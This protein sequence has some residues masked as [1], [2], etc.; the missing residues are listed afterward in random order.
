MKKTFL[1]LGCLTLLTVGIITISCKKDKKDSASG[2]G[3]TCKG[4]DD[5]GDH[6]VDT[7][8]A[9]DLKEEGLSSCGEIRTKYPEYYECKS[10]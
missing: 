4:Y 2:K 8:T 1:L 6:Y 5:D 7:W 9:E 3:C 10:N